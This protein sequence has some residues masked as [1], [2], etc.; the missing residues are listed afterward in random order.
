MRCSLGERLRSG[1]RSSGDWRA[2]RVWLLGRDGGRTRAGGGRARR[3]RGRGRSAR[4]RRHRLASRRRS[5]GRSPTP[6]GFDVV[7][8]AV[9]VLGAQAGLDADPDEAIEVMRVNFVGAGLAAARVPSPAAAARRGDACAAVVGR[10]RASPGLQPDLRSGQGRPRCACPGSL[11]R[12]RVERRAR[13]RRPPRVRQ[14]P[15]DC[16]SR[17]GPVR[18]DAGGRRVS[19]G[20]SSGRT[21]G[22]D[23]GARSAA[24]RCS[25]SSGTCPAGSTGGSRCETQCAVGRRRDRDHRGDRRLDDH[26]RSGGG[27]NNRDRGTGRVRD[28]LTTRIAPPAPRS[29]CAASH[30]PAC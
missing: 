29:R 19:D 15:D 18:D 30:H 25:R 1:S 13:T 7:V 27:R 2:Q 10:G 9:G 22:N 23:L 26:P 20:R 16:R 28:Q 24:A 3:R 6:S 11:R 21:R 17:A 4:R 8:I 5:S 14:D 12:D